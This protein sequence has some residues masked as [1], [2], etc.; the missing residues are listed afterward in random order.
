[1]RYNRL[2]K[3]KNDTYLSV[4]GLGILTLALCTTGCVPKQVKPKRASVTPLYAIS[5]PQLNTVDF[6]FS[7]LR[8]KVAVV[9][10]FASYCMPCLHI[11]PKLKKLYLMNRQKGFLVVGV[12]LDRQVSQILKP[13]VNYLQIDYP[14]LVANATIY[15]G[16]TIFG[17]IQRIPHSVLIDRCGRVRRVFV[18]VPNMKVMETEVQRLLEQKASA[19]SGT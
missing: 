5:L 13:F 19:C 1:M 2:R 17:R 14:V 18:G 4:V 16:T 10:F 9:D 7:A 6:P 8:G 12:A 3:L 15:R 11:I